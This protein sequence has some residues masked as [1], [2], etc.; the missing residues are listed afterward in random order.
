MMGYDDDCLIIMM[1]SN[2]CVK[3]LRYAKQEPFLHI[4]PLLSTILYYHVYHPSSQ[5]PMYT[6]LHYSTKILHFME[7]D[8]TPLPVIHTYTHTHTHTLAKRGLVANSFPD[9]EA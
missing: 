2:I 4:P 9:D 8:R 7:I 3:H 1:M 5:F 6:A